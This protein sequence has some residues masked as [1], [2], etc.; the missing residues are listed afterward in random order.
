M[1]KHQW[2]RPYGALPRHRE[3]ETVRFNGSAGGQ[4]FR[5][6]SLKIYTGYKDSQSV[7]LGRFKNHPAPSE[8]DWEL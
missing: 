8:N 2:S 6:V 7:L 1:A 3:R 4:I 5:L